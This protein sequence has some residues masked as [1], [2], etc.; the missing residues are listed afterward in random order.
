MIQAELIDEN[1]IGL[2]SDFDMRDRDRIKQL[3][4]ARYRKGAWTV[5]LSWGACIQLR[6]VFGQE[7]QV[8]E[9]LAV[10]SNDQYQ[11]RIK[12]NLD[13]RTATKLL[14]ED[15]ILARWR[16]E[17]QFKLFPFQEAG[18][19]FLAT[20][21]K[22]YL[23]DEMGAGKTCQA[24]STLR[25]LEELGEDPWPAA[26]VV[27]AS[28]IHSWKQELEEKWLP[29]RKVVLVTGSAAQRRKLLAEPAD[30]YLM[31]YNTVKAHSKL[32]GYGGVRLKTCHVCD[33][34]LPDTPEFSQAKCETCKKELNFMTFP[35]IIIDEAHMLQ[36]PKAKQTRAIWALQTKDTKNIY[37][38]SGT[39]VTDHPGTM[40]AGLSIVE[41]VAFSN[42][43]KFIDRYVQQKYSP[44]GG[45]NLEGLKPETKQ[46]FFSIVDPFFRRMPKEA[47]LPFLPKKTYTTRYVEMTP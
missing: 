17:D 3:P 37:L 19:K 21:R 11:S 14:E 16:E 5:P 20:A 15:P 42:R 36:D 27:K 6:G 28:L 29:G 13:L 38:L 34:S 32:S 8:G 47:V 45:F 10:W 33:N 22:A 30:I 12:P 4:G 44:F 39:P 46:E 1:L 9:S 40:W 41:P 18:I 23:C 26:I 31:T 24:A 2:T 25:Y 35:S 43:S 7:L